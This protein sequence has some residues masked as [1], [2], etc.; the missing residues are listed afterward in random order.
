MADPILENK[1]ISIL[2][3]IIDLLNMSVGEFEK[4]IPKPVF[5]DA[6]IE[7]KRWR[8]EQGSPQVLQVLM[9]VRVA[10]GLRACVVLLAN[11][12]MTEIGVLLRTI[13]DFLGEITFVDEIIEKGIEN[14]TTEHKQFL[15]DYFFD[16]NRT[17]EEMLEDSVNPRRKVDFKKHRQKMQASEARFLGGDDPHHIKKVSKTIDDAWSGVVHGSYQSVMEMYG[18]DSIE[19]AHFEAGGTGARFSDYRHHIGLHVHHALNQFF[20]VAYNLG[21]TELAHHLREMRRQFE[22][23]P[24]Y[25]A[26]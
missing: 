22:D 17:T 12:Q 15:E 1:I 7:R 19:T 6:D 2:F 18:G 20:K 21:H 13:D 14:C 10:S 8:F 3:N 24:A 5:L 4:S 9:C 26:R 16:N 25:T 11:G 23:S